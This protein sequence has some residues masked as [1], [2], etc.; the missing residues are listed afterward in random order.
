MLTRDSKPG[1]DAEKA[2]LA[3]LVSALDHART[4]GQTKVISYL[5]EVADDVVSEVEMRARRAS[6]VG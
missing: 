4:R 3:W 5:E 6:L 1:A 2:T